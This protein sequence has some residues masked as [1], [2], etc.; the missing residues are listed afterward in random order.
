MKNV[1]VRTALIGAVAL[2]A[3]LILLISCAG[4][5]MLG[6]SNDS[7]VLVHEAG[8]RVILINDVYKDSARTRAGLAMVYASLL[9]NGK[10]EDW[11]FKNIKTTYDRMLAKTQEF[12]GLSIV[13]QG[14]ESIKAELVE[15]AN[16]LAEMLDKATAFLQAGDV[17][18]YFELNVT[19]IDKAGGR[20]SQA[21]EKYQKSSQE[22]ANALAAERKQ[23]FRMMQ[24]VMAISLLVAVALT[25]AVLYMLRSV[26]L[27][28]LAYAIAQLDQVAKGDLTERIHVPGNNEMGRLLASISSM[29]DN[30]A[31]IVG[32]VRGGADGIATASGQIDAGNQDLSSRTEEQ[33]SALQQTAASIEEL[34]STVRQNADNAGQANKLAASTSEAA[35]ESGRVVA[36]VVT[37]VGEINDASHKIADIVGVIDGIASQINILALNAAVEAARAGEQGRGFAVVA[38]EVR[39]LA[40]RSLT[41]AK[42]IKALIENSVGKASEGVRQVAEAGRKVE[43]LVQSSKRVA[44]ILGEISA[45]STEQSQGIEQ[46]NQAIAQ[47]DT[48]TQQN[49]ALVEEAAAA[50]S[51]LKAQAA[52]LA[53]AVGVFR[54]RE[55]AG[56]NAVYQASVGS[57]SPR[58]AVR[59]T[60]K[61]PVAAAPALSLPPL[62]L[63]SGGSEKGGAW[64]SF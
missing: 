5:L 3:S 53:E 40:G 55:D 37:T 25:V 62:A 51:S 28:P 22:A 18:A 54:L 42:D 15:A 34:T 13:I 35:A 59:V 24:W 61:L 50:A 1:S 32:S 56:G 47:I 9:K 12:N 45:A 20:F 41:A 44:D 27:R 30:L 39:A 26:I 17:N 52:R 36:D 14:D 11:I 38:S 46:V 64:E 6:K 48:V 2:F 10:A 21:L 43:A 4:F 63:A 58:P 19:G 60:G 57:P 8:R 33:A 7:T 23:E 16:A 31:Q 29:Q 49:A